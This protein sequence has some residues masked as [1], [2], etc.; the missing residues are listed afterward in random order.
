MG[1]SLRATSSG[2]CLDQTV[3]EIHHLQLFKASFNVSSVAPGGSRM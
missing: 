1:P 3:S 2:L